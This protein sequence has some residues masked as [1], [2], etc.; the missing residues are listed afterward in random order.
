VNNF[1]ENLDN[2]VSK[3]EKGFDKAAGA[4]EKVGRGA[5]RVYIGC[6]TIAA[7]LFFAGFCLWGV[8]AGY[9]SWQLQSNGE[10]TTGT[11]VDLKESS[12]PETGCCTYSP[13]IEFTVNGSPYI[14]SGDNASNPP[15]YEVGETVEVLYDPADPDN[16]QINKWAERWLMPIIIIP[17]M[18]FASLLL[19]FFMVRAWR[20]DEAILE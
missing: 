14:F 1:D 6:V 18:I 3:Y 19:T 8:Y 15:A 20:R 10:T 7:N 9:I 5:N 2:A 11:V 13:V 12:H 17:A 4:I 16:A